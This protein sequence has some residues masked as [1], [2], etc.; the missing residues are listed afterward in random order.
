MVDDYLFRI[1]LKLLQERDQCVDGIKEEKDYGRNI[2]VEKLSENA[3]YRVVIIKV[4][5][6]NGHKKGTTRPNVIKL[7][8]TG[9]P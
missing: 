9:W 6:W 4:P 1:N 3:I 8:N 7:G 5:L 2:Y